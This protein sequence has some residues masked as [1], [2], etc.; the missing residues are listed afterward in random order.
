LLLHE[1]PLVGRYWCTTTISGLVLHAYMPLVRL[2]NSY[3]H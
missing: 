1:F 3:T 2:L